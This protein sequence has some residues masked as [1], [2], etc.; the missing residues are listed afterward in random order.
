[1]G[2]DKIKGGQKCCRWWEKNDQNC[3][4]TKFLGR[5][6]K[7]TVRDFLTPNLE[8]SVENRFIGIYGKTAPT[9]STVL[10]PGPPPGRKHKI[11]RKL[12]IF[13]VFGPSI[14]P[15]KPSPKSASTPYPPSEDPQKWKKWEILAKSGFYDLDSWLR[16]FITTQFY[17]YSILIKDIWSQCV[18]NNLKN[19]YQINY[20]RQF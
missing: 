3:Q 16:Q 20:S 19:R 8:K 5:R 14:Q 10:G 1:M 9:K 18:A 15:G 12:P 11:Y 6:K 4:K 7:S 17:T 13:W 2:R